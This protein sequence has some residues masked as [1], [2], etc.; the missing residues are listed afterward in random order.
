VTPLSLFPR[1]P[2]FSHLKRST[3]PPVRIPTPI[4]ASLSC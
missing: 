2:P 4:R 1:P 3:Y